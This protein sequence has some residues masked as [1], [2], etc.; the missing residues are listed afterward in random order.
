M[1]QLEEHFEILRETFVEEK[2]YDVFHKLERFKNFVKQETELYEDKSE[3]AKHANELV[4]LKIEEL[5]GE[6]Y[7][8]EESL[9]RQIR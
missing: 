5:F 2:K 4:W 3:A 6:I 8:L 9:K 7:D 1:K